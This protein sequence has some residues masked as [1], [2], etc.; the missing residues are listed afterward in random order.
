LETIDEIG[1]RPL[2]SADG[3]LEGV[4][5]SFERNQTL[6]STLRLTIAESA[7]NRT[8]DVVEI[9]SIRG[10]EISK[11]REGDETANEC[12]ERLH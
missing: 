12:L 8:A 10:R 9:N 5:R 2:Q 1:R 3:E 6:V 7:R 4:E 11:K